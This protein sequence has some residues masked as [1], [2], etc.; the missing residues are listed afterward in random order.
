MEYCI[1][2]HI[3]GKKYMADDFEFIERKRLMYN[4][5]NGCSSDCGCSDC[6]SCG[7][8]CS[9]PQDQCCNNCSC[10][11]GP[12]G[13]KGDPGIPGLPG[14]AATVTVGTTTTG[15]PGTNAQVT[16]SGTSSD[17]VLNFVIP[18]GATGPTGP[19]GAT[20]PTAPSIYAQQ[21]KCR[22]H[23]AFSTLK[24]IKQPL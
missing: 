23:A 1:I 2:K 8:S 22:N 19:Q 17:A 20:G 9:W 11:V 21:G 14:R 13:D 4:S 10:C 7:P 6:N 15:A 24:T 12:K 16:N 5:S 18:R 3:E